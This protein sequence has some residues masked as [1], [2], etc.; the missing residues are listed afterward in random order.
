MRRS[1][2][3]AAS[4][5]VFVKRADQEHPRRRI[6]TVTDAVCEA[7]EFEIGR[8]PDRV[9][10]G[11]GR[12]VLFEPFRDRRKDARERP[13]RQFQRRRNPHPVR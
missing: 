11:M 10:T 6:D 1:S 2:A 8:G 13:A 4:V 3:I 9:P 12:P 7:G 5:V